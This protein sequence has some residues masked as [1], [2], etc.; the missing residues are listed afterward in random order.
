[1]DYSSI[2]HQGHLNSQNRLDMVSV[3]RNKQL[4]HF[5]PNVEF[6]FQSKHEL[7]PY[8]RCLITILKK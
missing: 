4:N 1:M 3:T 7:L 8:F 2:L 6:Q 5:A